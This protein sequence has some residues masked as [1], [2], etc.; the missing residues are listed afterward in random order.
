[1]STTF[2]LNESELNVQFVNALKLLFKNQNLTLTVEA[3]EMDTT[4]YLT[5]N[6]VNQER[7]LESIKNINEGK[8]L[9][10]ISISALKTMADA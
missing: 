6:P 1:M 7:L 2:Q 8:H 10:E 3:E 4:A 5:S 9:T